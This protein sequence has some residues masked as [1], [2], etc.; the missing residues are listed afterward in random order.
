MKKE[1]ISGSQCSVHSGKKLKFFCEG[2][3]QL[4]CNNCLLSHQSHGLSSLEDA[5]L[6]HKSSVQKVLQETKAHGQQLQALVKAVDEMQLR[7]EK[8]AELVE[9]KIKKEFAELQKQIKERQ[10]ALLK[11]LNAQTSQRVHRLNDEKQKL[12]TAYVEVEKSCEMAE[13]ALTSES[14]LEFMLAKCQVTKCL[15]SACLGREGQQQ[16]LQQYIA[17]NDDSFEYASCH[18]GN[19][20]QQQQESKE[21][22]E[23]IHILT[24]M[25]Q[26][27]GKID[28]ATTRNRI[29]KNDETEEICKNVK[30]YAS[31]LSFTSL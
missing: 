1:E 12:E 22:I 2:C 15:R 21:T 11:E 10:S 31:L 14:G 3:D 5:T 8:K 17:C 4:I 19:V 26:T 29:G 16:H 20:H 9:D 18:N 28:V 13:K 25:I 27:F 7:V 30:K 24:G 23:G 6:K